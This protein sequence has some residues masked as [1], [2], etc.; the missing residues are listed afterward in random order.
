MWDASL[1]I[2]KDDRRILV[3]PFELHLVKD[4]APDR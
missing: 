4:A 2:E 3:T 1:Y